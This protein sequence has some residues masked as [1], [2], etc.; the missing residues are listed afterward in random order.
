MCHVQSSTGGSVDMPECVRQCR[1]VV[2]NG[3]NE[4]LDPLITTLKSLT[5]Y[6]RGI[7][8]SLEIGKGSRSCL[9]MNVRAGRIEYS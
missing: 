7:V 8:V 5:P 3:N 1:N 6:V 2:E 9:F 4:A